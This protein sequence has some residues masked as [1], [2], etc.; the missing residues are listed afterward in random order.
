MTERTNEPVTVRQQVIPGLAA[1][2]TTLILAA[3][4]ATLLLSKLPLV[5]ARDLLGSDIPW[6]IPAWMVT[7][8]LLIAVTFIWTVLKPLRRYFAVMGVILL[9]PLLLHPLITQLPAWLALVDGQTPMVGIF[10]DRLLLVLDTLLVLCVLFLLGIKRR[11][12]FL[13]IGDMQAPI[14]GQASTTTQ[15]RRLSWAVLA[16]LM[17]V[18]L[19]GLFY[20]FL[21][22]QTPAGAPDFMVVFPWMPLILLSAALNAFGEEAQF[23][24]APLATLLPAVGPQHAI[25]LTSLW[26]GLGHYY[27]GFPSGPVGLVYS[28]G[29]AL[30]MGKAMLDTRG[31]G[32]SWIIHLTIDTVIYIFLSTAA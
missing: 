5:I 13:T 29:L 22:S 8:I 19:A 1:D 30:L 25:W 18:L 9:A 3:W 4:A 16:P 32:W 6:I 10:G 26:F 31:L 15:K 11:E 17:A 24:A 23:R 20:T 12:A 21:A 2:R 7:A 28:G 27:G 14:G